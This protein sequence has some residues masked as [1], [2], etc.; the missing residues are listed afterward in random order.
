[1]SY[2]LP[3]GWIEIKLGDIA[4]IYHGDSIN[5]DIKKERYMK[6][7]DGWNYIATKDVGFDSKV[8]YENGVI[9]P[10]SENKFKIAPAGSIF[11][12]S[13]GGSAGRKS[14][15]VN[16]DVCFGNK[17]FAITNK[18]G[19]F[20]GKYVFYYTRCNQFAER[21]KEK[22]NGIIGG[23]GSKKFSEI[24]IPL[25]SL[26]DQKCIVE[27]LDELVSELDQGVVDLLRIKEQL[28]VYR[29]SVLKD[30]FEGRLTKKINE[31]ITDNTLELYLSLLRK[32]RGELGNNKSYEV[33]E[34][35]DLPILPSSLKWVCIGDISSGVEYGSAQKSDKHGDV[36]VLRMGNIQ[37]GKFDWNDL[38]YSSDKIEIDKYLLKYND[39]LFNRTNSPEIV[40]KTAIYCNEQPAIFAGYLI[41]INQLNE[42][43]AKYLNYFLNSPIAKL[44]GNRV[45]TDGVNQSNINGTK[46]CS[47]PF[48]LCT[49]SRQDE[50]VL[51]IESRLSV[52]DYVE[53]I[54]NNTL[55]KAESLR[56]GILKSAF[57]G[58]LIK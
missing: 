6:S 40:G 43:N 57:E 42:I 30:A 4:S 2:K 33:G 28:E 36:A 14:A 37:N 32:K 38:A 47:Y 27:K 48:P 53:Q 26:L 39:V 52:C 19:A 55:G 49:R 56:E 16:R 44:Y 18:S 20:V 12:C 23:V 1:M 34:S 25:P 24:I 35:M 54:V 8:N 17:L 21:F 7:C 3:A 46:L 11:V 50:I 9:I 22:M 51:E 5:A 10:H 31:V 41:R 13:E 45:K 15:I 58:K 29:H